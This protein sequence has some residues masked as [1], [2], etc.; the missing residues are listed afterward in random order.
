MAGKILIVDGDASSRTYLSAELKKKGYETLAAASGREG[1][2]AAWRDSPVLIVIDPVLADVPGEEVAV[3]L[4]SDARTAA[5]P[6]IALSSDSQPARQQACAEAGFT[7]YMIKGPHAMANLLEFLVE[8]MPAEAPALGGGGLVMAFLSAKGGTGTSSLCANLAMTMAAAEP[9]RRVAV[10]DLVLPIGSIAGIVGCPGTQNL[11]T[12]SGLAPE[13]TTPELLRSYLCE[14][15]GWGFHLLPGSPDPEHGNSVKAE[16][17]AGLIEALKT[18]H[19]YVLLDLGRSLSR[20]SLP[21]IEKADLVV[22][23]LSPDAST[24]ALSK[25]VWD[26]LQSKGVKAAAMHV[27]LNRAVGLEGLARAEIEKTVGLPIHTAFPYLGGNLSVANDHHQ[28]YALKYPG[29]TTTIVLN[30][31]ARQMIAAAKLRLLN[32]TPK[33]Q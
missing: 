4:R 22:M 5:V 20:I 12:A 9:T 11:V 6:L 13:E 17:I 8:E 21:L 7:R 30:D 3:R 29:D 18:S 28:P 16:R 2:I 15:A 14:P 31:T 19:D 33:V 32:V 26:F 10:A 23:V 27:I 24:A 1:L 25:I